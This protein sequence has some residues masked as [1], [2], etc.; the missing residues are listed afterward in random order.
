MAMVCQVE[1]KVVQD[2]NKVL[3]TIVCADPGTPGKVYRH[4]KIVEVPD[5]DQKTVQEVRNIVDTEAV[6]WIAKVES[7][8]SNVSQSVS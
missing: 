6:N 1:S 7:S 8:Y 4:Q 2:Y 3:L 5:A